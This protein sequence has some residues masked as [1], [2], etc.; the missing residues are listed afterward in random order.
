MES[1]RCHIMFT[2][3]SEISWALVRKKY[4]SNSLKRVEFFVDPMTTL[5]LQHMMRMFKVQS[6]HLINFTGLYIN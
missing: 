3:V 1:Y 6:L 5:A 4:G 2:D